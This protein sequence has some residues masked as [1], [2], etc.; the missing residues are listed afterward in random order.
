M[1]T[2]RYFAVPCLLVF[3][4]ACAKGDSL[5]GS[6][7]GNDGG[8]PAQGGGDGAGNQ[9][10][11]TTN[12]TVMGTNDTTTTG[13]M[14][15]EQP[16]KLVAPQCGCD[17]GFACVPDGAGSRA[18][19]MAGSSGQSDL[20]DEAEQCEAGTLCVGYPDHGSSCATFCNTDDDCDGPG[21]KCALEVNGAPICTEN[22]ELATSQ[23]CFVGSTSCQVSITDTNEPFTLCA[24]SGT[25]V[26]Q[27]VC[28][29]SSGC[30]PSFVCLPTDIGDS[31]CFQWCNVGAPACPGDLPNCTGLDAAEGVPLV[32]GNVHYG[33][34][35]P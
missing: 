20:C 10:G 26:A 5:A 23:G 25:G 13:P 9:G 11:D 24:P 7:G 15:D 27:T 17:D 8:G 22:C 14:C 19:I 28:T 6:G 1:L 31:R 2:P 3:A 29:D 16:C 18:C 35:N 12:V 32:I 4:L 21:G 34:C 30:A 33:V